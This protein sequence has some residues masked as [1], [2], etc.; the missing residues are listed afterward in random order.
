MAGIALTPPLIRARKG[1]AEPLVMLTAYT[2]P[3]ARALDAHADILLVGDSVGM[4]VYGMDSTL[5]VDLATMI[6]HG[7]AVAAAA[8]RAMVVVDLPFATYH[9]SPQKA[10]RSAAKVLQKTGC[11]AVKLEGGAEMAETV[12]FLTQRG[13]PVMGHIGLLPQSVR[14][15]GGYK[16]QGDAARLLA[17]ARALE[18]AGAFAVVLEGV[19]EPAARAVTEGVAVPTIGIGA[20]AACDGQVLVCDDM[21]GLTPSGGPRP[22]FVRR[23][24]DLY[25]QVE[26]AAAQFATDVRARTFPG[27]GEE[28]H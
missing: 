16:V 25:A 24:A 10:F 27:Q 11:A 23:Y 20:S 17:D 3:V 1:A 22:R 18:Q 21:L 28:Y 15:M 2:A 12:A 13:V 14:V 8:E 5:P 6:R 19:K 9:E 4:A 26:A 7:R